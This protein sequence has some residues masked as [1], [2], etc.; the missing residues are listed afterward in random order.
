ME[1]LMPGD[2]TADSV[3]TGVP[4]GTIVGYAGDAIPQGWLLCDGSQRSKRT[5]AALFAVVRGT[6]GET[7]ETFALP[8]LRGRS[9]VG[10]GVG[11]GLTPRSRG[12]A[13]GVESVRLSI[14]EMPSHAHSIVAHREG[15]GF[16]G[17]D[18]GGGAERVTTDPAGGGQPH[19]NMSP[20]LVLRYLIKH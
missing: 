14:A 9:I 6:F 15:Q 3:V 11:P 16:N 4:V 20:S 5:F 8:D 7:P 12:Q 10:D 2:Q 1:V 17:V 19:E 13:F 18:E